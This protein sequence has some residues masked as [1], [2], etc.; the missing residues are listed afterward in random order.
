MRRSTIILV[1]FVLIAGGL[2]GLSQFLRSQPPYTL[3]VAVDPLAEDW[4]RAAAARFNESNATL[5][6]SSQRVVVNISSMAD[7]RVWQGQAGWSTT[8]HPTGWVP[9]SSDALRSVDVTMPF[10]PYEASLARTPL[11][12]GGFASR[13]DL[14]TQ[15]GTQPFDWDAV[16]A[17]AAAERWQ[18][19]GAPANWGNVNMGLLWPASSLAG[20]AVLESAAI[21]QQGRST[22]DRTAL[23]SSGFR[24]WFD[25]IA[26]SM[27]N[28]RRLGESP[29]QAMAARGATVADF[30]LLPE[31]LWL[32][33]LGELSQRQEAMIFAYPAA[34]KLL[35]FPLAIWE[36]AETDAN[37]RAALRAFADYLLSDAVQTLAAEYGLRP[38]LLPLTGAEPLFA[39]GLP[40][41]IA[42]EA[43]P[44]NLAALSRPDIESLLRLLN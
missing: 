22:L 4:L 7:L 26:A 19:L 44:G 12:W 28:A 30:A 35:D 2:I 24:A 38:V 32:R 36:D 33:S 21:Q 17:A 14:I 10:R 18:N 41:G 9:A 43:P 20:V 23:S 8:A 25:P 40:F 34:Q 27:N 15:Q 37:E 6:G 3:E 31:S 11:L 13:V 5:P 1:L 16:A 29:A 39:A 42:L